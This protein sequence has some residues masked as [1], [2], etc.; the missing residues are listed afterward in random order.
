MDPTVTVALYGVAGTAV[1]ALAGVAGAVFGPTLAARQSARLASGSRLNDLR[2]AL[3]LKALTYVEDVAAR[4]DGLSDPMADRQGR[5][6][7][8]ATRGEI[9]A[10]LRLLAESNVLDA[11]MKLVEADVGLAY[12]EKYDNTLRFGNLISGDEPVVRDVVK[13]VDDFRQAVRRAVGS[14]K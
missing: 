3:Y 14:D 8:V 13:A 2:S 4:L 10:E 11:W 6:S 1:A 12:R 5:P 9:T 7:A